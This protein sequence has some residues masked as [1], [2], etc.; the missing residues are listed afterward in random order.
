[1]VYVL[2]DVAILLEF[3]F[4]AAPVEQTVIREPDI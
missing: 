3:F 1:M 2:D 4:N